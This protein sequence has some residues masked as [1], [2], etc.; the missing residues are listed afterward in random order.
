MELDAA[1]IPPVPELPPEARRPWRDYIPLMIFCPECGQ[2]HDTIR[3]M[4]VLRLRDGKRSFM[5]RKLAHE[6]PDGKWCFAG[7][8][9]RDPRGM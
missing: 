3:V 8:D 5:L 1:A 7:V 4:R 2:W 9:P 6:L